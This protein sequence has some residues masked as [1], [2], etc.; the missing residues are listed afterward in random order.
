MISRENDPSLKRCKADKKVLSEDGFHANRL[1]SGLGMQE[2]ASGNY[3][4]Y[5]CAIKDSLS[6]CETGS[7]YS[8]AGSESGSTFQTSI[9]ELLG[10][11][12]ETPN[13]KLRTLPDQT[14]HI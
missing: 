7:G 2:W 6:I 13:L 3:H 14:I 1:S 5:A 4:T 11:K 12:N 9:T 10:E 8:N